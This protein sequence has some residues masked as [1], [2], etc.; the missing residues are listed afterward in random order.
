MG[1]GGE[2]KV[3]GRIHNVWGGGETKV[4]GRIHTMMYGG[5]I[6]VRGRIHTMYGGGGNQSTWSH[7][8]NVLGG[9][10]GGA[11]HSFLLLWMSNLRTQRVLQDRKRRELRERHDLQKIMLHKF[12]MGKKSGGTR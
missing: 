12:H 3:R 8:H 4:R 9:G 1:G 7:P 2:I 6:K 11:N 10:G 5:G